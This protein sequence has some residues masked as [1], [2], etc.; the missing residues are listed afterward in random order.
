MEVGGGASMKIDYAAN[1]QCSTYTFLS[2]SVRREYIE[3]KI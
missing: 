3:I 1:V 2:T